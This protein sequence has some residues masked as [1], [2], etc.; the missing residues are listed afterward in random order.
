MNLLEQTHAVMRYFPVSTQN[1]RDWI[2]NIDPIIEAAGEETIED[3]RVES[4]DI[5]GHVLNIWVYHGNGEFSINL[6]ISI[7]TA[8]DPIAA[9]TVYKKENGLRKIEEEIT[10]L[11]NRLAWLEMKK[12]NL[13]S[14]A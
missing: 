13:L 2:D 11:T 5:Y 7:L 8:D 6:P 12:I 4:I 3:A 1:L 14:E 10:S 9:A